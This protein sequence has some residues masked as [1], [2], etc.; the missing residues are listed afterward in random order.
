MR[1][2]VFL[3][4]NCYAESREKAQS[5]INE[6]MVSV[7]GII[8]EKNSYQVDSSSLISVLQ[9][10]RYV[11]RGAYKLLKAIEVFNVVFLNKTVCD[12]GASTGGFT[13]VSLEYGASRVYAVD[14]GT[15]QLHS[16]LLNDRRV[17]NF[18]KTNARFLCPKTLGEKVD[19]V[20]SDVSF[21]SQSLIYDAVSGIMKD[22]GFFISLIK[23]QFEVGRSGLGKNGI[24]KNK[25]SIYACF[26]YLI[27]EAEKRDLYCQNI[28][29]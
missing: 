22:N 11:S 1:L 24:V 20:L 19:I 23:P 15:G 8:I 25:D 12:I 18:E 13:Q 9:S 10:Q 5:L 28:I 21:I 3:V 7:N 27:N 14:C 29:G 17:I 2:D 6:G 26:V 4:N 16:S